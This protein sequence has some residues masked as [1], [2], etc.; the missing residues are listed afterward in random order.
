MK[1]PNSHWAIVDL[2]KLTEYC[3]NPLHEEGRHKARVFLSALG[4]GQMDAAWLHDRILEAVATCEAQEQL[5]SPYGRRYIVDFVAVREGRSAAV[6][7]AWI[8]K[9][10]DE[11]PRLTLCFVL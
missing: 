3:L 9:R 7:T 4:V 10:D 1:L 5:V 8:I 6:R 2:R 11:M